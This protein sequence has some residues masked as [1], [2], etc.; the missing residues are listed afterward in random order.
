MLSGLLARA[1]AL[2]RAARARRLLPDTRW[3]AALDAAGI[4]IED[5]ALEDDGSLRFDSAGLRLPPTPAAR[6]VLPALR[7][8]DE[9]HRHAGATLSWDTTL[10]AVRVHHAGVTYAADCVEEAWI[11]RELLLEGDYDLLPARTPLFVDVGANVGLASLYLASLCDDAQ[12]VGFEPLQM[13]LDKARRNVALN[14]ALAPRIELVHAALADVD[15]E[16]VLRSIAGHRGRSSLVTAPTPPPGSGAIPV[17]EHR[18]PV[19]RASAAI[20]ALRRAHPT[21]DVVLKLDCEGS[22]RAILDDL[23]RT[24]EL[25][26]IS[27]CVI[28][29][30]AQPG[31]PDSPQRL[32]ELLHGAGFHVHTRG[33]HRQ[34]R[35]DGLMLAVRAATRPG[36][37]RP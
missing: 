34:P 22:E 32:R 15:G 7:L 18:V 24:G 9:L 14:P 16:S 11:L 21:R 27:A 5:A 31:A 20:G 12:V 23:T 36:V 26:R 19:R 37:P 6:S 3:R 13:N 29:W 4:A 1:R 17:E 28:E 33:R 30:H 2:R 8:L 35:V 25:A 10:A